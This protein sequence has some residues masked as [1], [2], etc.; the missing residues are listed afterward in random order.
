M[1]RILSS[2]DTVNLEGGTVDIEAHVRPKPQQGILI[3]GKASIAEAALDAPRITISGIPADA[4]QFTDLK[5]SL[6]LALDF[7]LDEAGL[8][9]QGKG[10]VSIGHVEWTDSQ[11]GPSEISAK[12]KAAVEFWKNPKDKSVSF[13]GSANLDVP[14]LAAGEALKQAVGLG[15][16]TLQVEGP[17]R[18]DLAFAGKSWDSI[19]ACGSLKMD[20]GIL[21]AR[22]IIPEVREI[23]GDIGVSLA[24]ESRGGALTGYQ[25]QVRLISGCADAAY[26]GQGIE[27]LKGLLTG[28]MNFSGGEEKPVSYKGFVNI[29]EAEIALDRRL[30]PVE[31]ALEGDSYGEIR[32]PKGLVDGSV[33]F[34]GEYPGAVK[35]NGLLNLR[36]SVIEVVSGTTEIGEFQMAEGEACGNV[37]F[38]GE[39]PGKTEY[40]AKIGLSGGIAEIR[41]GLPWL[42][43]ARGQV[44]GD[45]ELLGNSGGE[46]AYSGDL[47]VT[48]VAIDVSDAPGGI[49]RFSGEG[50]IDV[51]FRGGGDDVLRYE[52][53]G[54]LKRGELLATDIEGYVRRLEGPVTGTVN[55]K[56]KYLE[57]PVVDG[58]IS[59]AK[60]DLEVG[61]IEGFI[62]SAKGE[63]V[64]E[65]CFSTHGTRLAT[66][67]GKGTVRNAEFVADGAVPGL[68]EAGG[69]GAVDL[70]FSCP[71]DGRL[72][73]DGKAKIHSG[74]VRAEQIYP[75]L[76]GLEGNVTSELTFKSGDDGIMYEGFADL[77]SGR[78]LLKG[79]IEGFD[80]M[81]GDISA[82]LKFQGVGTA[83]GSFQGNAV[84]SGGTLKVGKIAEGI[85]SIEGL[86]R[87]EAAFS[88]GFGIAPT[89]DGTLTISDASFRGSGFSAEVKSIAGKADSTIHFASN[90][91]GPVLFEGTATMS[92]VSFAAGRVYPGIKE[93]GGNGKAQLTFSGAGGDDLSYSG[94]VMITKGTL[95]LDFIGARLDNLVAE[96]DFDTESLDIKGV[97]GNFGKSR[98]EASGL[99]IF[100]KKPEVDINLKSKDLTLEDL[101]EIIVAGKPLSVSGTALLDVGV[102]GFYPDLELAG[103]VLLSDVEVEHAIIEL[104]AKSV[105]GKVKLSGNSVSTENL[106]MVF[107]DSPV[108]VK[109][110]VTGISDPHFD[111]TASFADIRL[112]RAKEVFAPDI[113]GDIEGR[114]KVTLNLT[115]S[116]EELWT[117]GDFALA[118]LSGE[119]GGKSLKASEAKGKFRYGNNAI[120]LT[121]IRVSAM[122][123]EI[124]AD[125]VTLLKKAE[126][127]SGPNPWTRL[128]LDI[129]GI[130]VEEAAS[131]VTS[132]EIATSGILDGKVMLEAEG[133]AYRVAGS[134]S[135]ASGSVQGYSFDNTKAEFRAENGRIVIDQLTSE[136]A[137]GRLTARGIVHDNAD[138]EA[139][140][141]TTAVDLEK[142]GQSL[143][144][145]GISGIAD[146]VGTVSGKDKAISV[147]GLAEITSPVIYGIQLDSAAGRISFAS[148]AIRLSNVSVTQGDAACQ[149]AGVIDLSR[150]DPGF[151]LSANITGIPIQELA[152]AM[153]I[154]E[155]PVNGRL[156]GKVAVRGTVKNPEAEGEVRLSSGEILGIKLDDVTTGFAYAADTINIKDLSAITGTLKISSSGVVTREGKLDLA[157]SIRDFDL[158]ELPID[159]QG[160]PI[161][162]GIADFDGKIAGELSEPQVEGLVVAKNVSVMDA[163][164]QDA[165]F[166]LKWG[167]GTVQVRRGVIHDRSGTAEAVGSIGLDKGNPLNLTVTALDL[168][169]KTVLAIGRP[170][171]NDPVEGRISGK[172]DVRGNLSEPVIDLKLN[173]SRLVVGGI[174]LESAS[175]DAEIAR[176]SVDLRFLRLFQA[177]GGYFEAGGSLGSGGPISLTASARSFDVSALSA[178]IGWK[179]SFKGN[180]DLAG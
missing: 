30:Q 134:C 103:E 71:E 17:A 108:L 60:C 94:K 104:P 42:R 45:I 110:S 48:H 46:L 61:E 58:V 141:A 146:F 82:N 21:A 168:D 172:A 73:Y 38:R 145:G 177:G 67:S 107:M 57:E 117:D 147:D 120:T 144:Y 32:L 157:V 152:S 22:N 41:D 173:T 118:N 156:S 111:I 119:V 161:R 99:V 9:C 180:M 86:A 11:F 102:R 137:D 56:G 136:G 76:D 135:I 116:L 171:K 101:G 55:V 28:T 64:G 114:G 4:G 106:R 66:Y 90:P 68:V 6:N 95:N 63:A 2:I 44:R 54:Y 179:Y 148:N 124:N 167:N 130:S 69:R 1:R 100:G 155:R 105:E 87:L 26:P 7:Q 153:G 31:P 142:L 77:T 113:A 35:Y 74:R 132:E 138:F 115:G 89:Y 143:G 12:G 149:I 49:K 162:G 19:E 160:N 36:D 83:R 52:G 20:K 10:S 163:L 140:V 65:I 78:V 139:Q 174:P 154:G 129:K 164:F 169:V 53:V 33:E 178:V 37:L 8:A 5:S 59:T 75:G 13:E 123:G 70:R 23:S 96:A 27:S 85:E 158:S 127:G 24:F 84:I 109:G 18:F 91:S 39:L 62:R 150:E 14:L 47:S 88:G 16:G 29:Q 159:I 98:F 34:E 126:D 81:D 93:L 51:N 151:D 50:S 15:G 125:G 97:T 43:Q 79:E 175:M 133:G 112:S 80:H 25:G 165:S 128:S 131:Y 166:D 92:N 40:G 72:T 121:D 170:G 122:G 176:D 3:R